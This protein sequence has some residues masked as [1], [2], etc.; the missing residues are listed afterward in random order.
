[1]CVTRTFSVQVHD[2]IEWAA[3]LPRKLLLREHNAG[4]SVG[5]PDAL[6]GG[7]KEPVHVLYQ[8]RYSPIVSS[9]LWYGIGFQRSLSICRSCRSRVSDLSLDRWFLGP[10]V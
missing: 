9:I 6:V 3:G 4:E 8:I 10:R 2:P 1:M 7:C 5:Y